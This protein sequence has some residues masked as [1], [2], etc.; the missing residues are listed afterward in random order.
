MSSIVSSVSGFMQSTTNKFLW[1][2]S[3]VSTVWATKQ[4]YTVKNPC[5]LV[6]ELAS[7]TAQNVQ[8]NQA[9][10]L[11]ALAPSFF[12]SCPYQTYLPTTTAF[13]YYFVGN[14]IFSS[15]LGLYQATSPV[16]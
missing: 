11:L 6:P 12:Y 1:A 5:F 13:S 8:L 2:Q 10:Y 16:A 15:N 7:T 4:S 3:A 14:G 9:A